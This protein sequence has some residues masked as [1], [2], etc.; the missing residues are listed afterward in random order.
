[1]LMK[2]LCKEILELV[3][4]WLGEAPAT[5]TAMAA[6][7]G[8]STSPKKR[9]TSGRPQPEH[10]TQQGNTKTHSCRIPR[11]TTPDSPGNTRVL[12]PC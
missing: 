9:T 4:R 2:E 6:R 12:G 8:P 7:A 3:Y 1:M 11:I 10:S 5:A